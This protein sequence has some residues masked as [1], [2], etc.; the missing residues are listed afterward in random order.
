[1]RG[2]R[3]LSIEIEAATLEKVCKGMIETI[4]YC[5]PNAYKG[6]IYRIGSPPDL[7]AQRITSGRID[8]KREKISWGLPAES[9]YNKPGK[10]WVD[11]R[12]EENR[13]L[14]AMGW[15]VERQKS[16]TAQQP[17]DDPRSIRLQ[18]E[19]LRED[20]HHMEPVLVRKT[21]LN[22][23]FSTTVEYPRNADGDIIWRNYD[24][25]VVAVVKIHFKP[26]SIRMGSPETKVIKKLSRSLGT[27]LL[28][29]QL[30]EVSMKAL[31]EL[32]KD[33]LQ[34][35][36]ILS[37]SLRNAITKS[38][39]IFSLIKQEIGFLREHWEKTL[40]DMRQEESEKEI[41]I[42]E[43]Q[44]LVNQ[45]NS[46]REKRKADLRETQ[47]RFLKLSLSPSKGEQWIRMQIE[48]RWNSF[49][50]ECPK[51]EQFKEALRKS[52][53]R[54]KKSLYFGQDP[55]VI[56]S[57]TKIPEDMKREWVDLIYNRSDQFNVDVIDQIIQILQNHEIDIPSR[58]K[59]NRTLTQL[60]ALGET[61]HHLERNT[62]FLLRQV[63]NGH[64]EPMPY[65]S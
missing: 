60:K 40:L 65:R 30:R 47:D 29:W 9:E 53:G 38:G 54:L 62:N 55:D 22:P 43:L 56:A 15:C 13:P 19:G 61:M 50:E 3:I 25:V 2:H 31:Q 57:Y 8:R 41:A 4:L 32:T 45:M 5:L 27:E 59:V 34:A 35:C 14:E 1:L 36:D 28:S 24:F 52:L 23:E 7:I 33:R 46:G 12:D 10:L 64:Y 51:D 37:D 42:R 39:L 11:Y 16:W 18:V 58:E 17:S 26:N 21:D 44:E 6:T 63:L 20:Y 49:L 48:E